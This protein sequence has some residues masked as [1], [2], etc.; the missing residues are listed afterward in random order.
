MTDRALTMLASAGVNPLVDRFV[1]APAE[2]ALATVVG[3]AP[4]VAAAIGAFVALWLLAR[5]ARLVTVRL[6]RLVKLDEAIEETL[7]SR[8]F[9]SLGEG[10]TPSEVLGTIVSRPSS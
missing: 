10:S 1:I 5:V 4:T 8:I 9:S 2:H 7:I 3:I 6:L